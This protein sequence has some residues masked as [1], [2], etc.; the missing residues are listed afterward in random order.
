MQIRFPQTAQST[1]DNVK[2]QT[3]L[4]LS[5]FKFELTTMK[6]MPGI[7]KF[8]GKVPEKFPFAVL[9]LVTVRQDLGPHAAPHRQRLTQ[10][11]HFHGLLQMA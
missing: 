6:L 9:H 4:N 5:L 10:P 7:E 1:L 3:S 11:P 2:H 8:R